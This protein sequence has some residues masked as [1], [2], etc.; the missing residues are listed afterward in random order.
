MPAGFLLGV[1]LGGTDGIS[2]YRR[3]REI[4]PVNPTVGI[5]CK[6]LKQQWDK[7][8]KWR[9]QWLGRSSICC[10]CWCYFCCCEFRRKCKS[11]SDHVLASVSAWATV[12]CIN[13]LC[14]L[15]VTSFFLYVLDLNQFWF[16]TSTTSSPC[17]FLKSTSCSK[18][19]V[20]EICRV[21]S[22]FFN[23][24]DIPHSASLKII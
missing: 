14:M 21:V 2:D 1:P 10:C 18:Y 24:T 6:W 23:L 15:N 17:W 20:F 7:M 13:I 12:W 16:C 8:I 19:L 11:I 3:T 9:R 5:C 4:L 22:F